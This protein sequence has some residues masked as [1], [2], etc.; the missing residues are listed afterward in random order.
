MWRYLIIGFLVA[1]GLV[2]V[3][4]WARPTSNA[5]RARFDPGHSWLWG[6]RRSLA[7]IMAI[8][9]AAF[10]IVGGALLWVPLA[11]WRL[12]AVVG[13][14]YSLGLMIVYF[15]RRFLFIEVVNGGLI[16]GLAW[17]TW[18]SQTLLGM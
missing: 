10:L 3:A 14:V 8:S 17:T 7:L 12:L 15:N 2:H 4:I 1:H 16:L 5:R 6:D 11:S 18:P 9:A 13:L